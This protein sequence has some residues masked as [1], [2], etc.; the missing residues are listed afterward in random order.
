MA[1]GLHI[2]RVGFFTVNP[3]T[4]LVIDKNTAKI[5]D[6]LRTKS[7][8]R[9]I[10]DA[11]IANTINQPTVKGYLELEAGS[12]YR[13]LYMNENVIVT[14]TNPGP[15]AMP[16]TIHIAYSEFVGVNK[17]G[18]VVDKNNP[19]TTIADVGNTEHQHRVK[20]DAAIP[21]TASRPSIDTYLALEAASDFMLQ[22]MDQRYIITYKV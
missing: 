14:T 1:I 11:T 5:S 6:M 9:M 12:G 7:E 18:Q 4:N 17:L 10:L 13:L 8:H 3:L 2:A 19:L 20:V 15:F 16:L 22:Y 21:S